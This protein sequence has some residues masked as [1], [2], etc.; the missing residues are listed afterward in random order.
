V[1]IFDSW[2]GLLSVDD[3][4]RYALP[5]IRRIV[6]SFSVTNG[7]V[8]LYVNGSSH[9]LEAMKETGAGVLSVDWRLPLDEVRRR[10]GPGPALQGNLDPCALFAPSAMIRKAVHRIRREAATG[11]HILNL[12][13]GILPQT[14]VDGATAMVGASHEALEEN[15]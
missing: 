3:Y 14:P 1:Q 2:G 11:G 13:H 6:D 10:V 7:P 8:I 15:R 5:R 9:L 4:R 12:G